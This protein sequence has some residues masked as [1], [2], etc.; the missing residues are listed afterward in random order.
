M[1]FSEESINE[2]LENNVVIYL[3][4]FLVMFIVGYFSYNHFSSENLFENTEQQLNN[5]KETIAFYTNK[6]LLFFNMEGNSIKSTQ[7]TSF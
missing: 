5:M 1:E 2:F 3:V 4:L 7:F 6:M